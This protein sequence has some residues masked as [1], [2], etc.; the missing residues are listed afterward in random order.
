MRKR[1]GAS[2]SYDAV[3]EQIEIIRKLERY[4]PR[5][6]FNS[7][8]ELFKELDRTQKLPEQFRR[9]SENIWLATERLFEEERR[10]RRL[11][12]PSWKAIED[13]LEAARRMLSRIDP[14]LF[15]FG[16]RATERAEKAIDKLQSE[17]VRNEYSEAPTSKGPVGTKKEIAAAAEGIAFFE[18]LKTNLVW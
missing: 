9:V 6:G 8:Q 13:H 16:R 14:E 3:W 2:V 4:L 12:F 5:S 11:G 18:M 17:R 10:L 15:T 1:Y 7:I